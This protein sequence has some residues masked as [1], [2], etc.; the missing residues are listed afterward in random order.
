MAE[1]V[2]AAMFLDREHPSARVIVITGEGKK[3]FAAGADIKEMA[4]QSYAEVRQLCAMAWRPAAREFW[5][6]QSASCGRGAAR[7]LGEA[8]GRASH[9]GAARMECAERAPARSA[10]WSS[11]L[12][13]RPARCRQQ[14]CRAVVQNRLVGTRTTPHSFTVAPRPPAHTPRT[15]TRR[16]TTSSCSTAGTRCA[17]CAS[18]SSPP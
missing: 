15:P 3:A 17:W 13:L 12:L 1:L 6:A 5:A 4:Q 14:M 18:P 7:A 8:A 11:I 16:P 10:P 9:Q 2:S